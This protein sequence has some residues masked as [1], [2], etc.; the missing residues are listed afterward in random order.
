MII[1][2][3]CNG[4]GRYAMDK[5]IAYARERQ[6]WGVPIG[7]HQGVAHP[8]AEAKIALESARCGQLR[9]RRRGRRSKQHGQILGRRGGDSLHGSG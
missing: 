7:A 2:S 5:A 6:V 4:I 9:R 3:I 1:A 8:L